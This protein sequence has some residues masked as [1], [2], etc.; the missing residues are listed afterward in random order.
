MSALAPTE[1]EALADWARRVRANRDQAERVREA[2]ERPDFYAPVAANFRAAPRRTDEEALT[3]LLSLVREG[4]RWLDIGAG[5]GRY[6]LA[7]ALAARD[8]VALDPSEGMLAV[9][10]EGMA[11]HEIQ[12]IEV[13]QSRWPAEQE[14]RADACLMS[15][16]GYDI[17]EIGPF[18]DAMEAAAN[19]LCVAI[20]LARSPAFVA[21][22][23]W[24]AVH[25]ERREPLPAL[26]EFLALQLA[27]G[28]NC[29]VRLSRR[30]PGFFAS[31][32]A[33]LGFLR[34]QL[35]VEPGGPGDTKLKAAI[36]A[37]PREPDGRI[38]SSMESV[39]LGVVSWLP[40]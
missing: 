2:P 36:A 15:H 5:G 31:E 26:R 25:G 33:A 3:L 32:E 10:R 17:E 7:L 22:P 29:E 19:R 14:L 24:P 11:E 6:A 37:L 34:Q 28:R 13:V 16:I 40:R 20:L 38:A 27:R 1:T 23:F 21:E 9:L 8:V 39:P 18:L 4:D 35:F 30:E 12:N